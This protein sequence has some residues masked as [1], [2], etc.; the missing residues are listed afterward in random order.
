MQKKISILVLLLLVF[1]VNQVTFAAS[2]KIKVNDL[3]VNTISSQSI[4]HE[5]VKKN[6]DGSKDVF[7]KTKDGKTVKQKTYNDKGVLIQTI[8]Y[9]KNIKSI[10]S[11][12]TTK[13][14]QKYVGDK[15]LWWYDINTGNFLAKTICKGD[16]ICKTYGNDNKLY[17]GIVSG[18][19]YGADYTLK[20]KNGDIDIYSVSDALKKM[21]IIDE[22]GEF[23]AEPY[24]YFKFLKRIL[25]ADDELNML[26]SKAITGLQ[27]IIDTH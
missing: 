27:K 11:Y 1:C 24:Y 2:T 10:Y 4:Y 3:N 19:M 26:D 18:H 22:Q 20:Y 9:Q 25:I 7:V 8:D 15:E 12:K 23:L 21:E 13:L 6:S 16:G 17:T 5:E 14:Y